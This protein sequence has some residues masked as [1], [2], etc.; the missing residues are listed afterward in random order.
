MTKENTEGRCRLCGTD[1]LNGGRHL[2][3]GFPGRG[4]GDRCAQGGVTRKGGGGLLLF[5]NLI[6]WSG[7]QCHLFDGFLSKFT[8]A[9]RSGS[10]FHFPRSV[11]PVVALQLLSPASIFNEHDYKHAIAFCCWFQSRIFASA[12]VSAHPPSFCLAKETVAAACGAVEKPGVSQVKKRIEPQ[13]KQNRNCRLGFV[14]SCIIE[15]SPM[16]PWQ[17]AIYEPAGIPPSS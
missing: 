5:S 6:V 1:T 2:L 14:S 4:M 8:S 17:A 12:C 15:T 11:H 10:F 13:E 3:I 16:N 7:W 9:A